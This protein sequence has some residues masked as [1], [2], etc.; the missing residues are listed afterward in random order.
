MCEWIYGR[1]PVNEVL[2]AGRRDI[3]KLILFQEARVKGALA[4]IIQQCQ[5]E[6]IPIERVPR[7]RFDSFGSGHQGVALQTSEYP[8]QSLQDILLVADQRQEPHF[9]LILDA[10]QD[11]QNMGTLLRTAEIVGIH[12]VIIP[13]RHSVSL[14]P[15]VVNVSSGASE[16]LLIARANL[17]Q[18][19]AQLKVAGV[20]VIGLENDPSCQSPHNINLD[21][22]LAL[23]VG[24]EGSG[25]RSLV[26]ESCDLLMCLPMRGRINSLN[27]SVAGSVCLYLAWQARG[28]H[29]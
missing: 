13:L 6:N 19:I 20:W 22:P 21:G 15:A 5:Q 3:H 7:Q 27:A 8:Y 4:E 1:N 11:P 28:F 2:R 29:P 24:N 25:I 18:S 10:L 17:A 12:G 26:R 23:V 16:H 14:T 9:V